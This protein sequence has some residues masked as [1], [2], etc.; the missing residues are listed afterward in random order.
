M[1]RGNN[2]SLSSARSEITGG[3]TNNA[4]YNF[5]QNKILETAYKGRTTASAKRST[6]ELTD[7][8]MNLWSDNRVE[9][10]TGSKKVPLSD[11]VAGHFQK[12]TLLLSRVKNEKESLPRL[13]QLNK[14]GNLRGFGLEQLKNAPQVI[15]KRENEYKTLRDDF[16]KRQNSVLRDFDAN[17]KDE[18]NFNPTSRSI[19][20]EAYNELNRRI[21]QYSEAFPENP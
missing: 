16:F 17:R 12:L 9:T 7:R 18:K 21:K 1:A 4:S 3:K 5:Y 15:A 14:E 19:F 10:F 11:W 6:A 2:Q 8:M 13:E 20:E